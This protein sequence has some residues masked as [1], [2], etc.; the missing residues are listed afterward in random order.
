MTKPKPVPLP[1]ALVVTNRSKTFGNISGEMPTPVS[2]SLMTT[3]GPLSPDPA[4]DDAGILT[5]PPLSASI[6]CVVQQVNEYPLD[7]CAVAV[8]GRQLI[9]EH[10]AYSH[11]SLFEDW[12]KQKQR[13]AD[14]FIDIDF[15]PR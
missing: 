14:Q 5:L 10:R 7:G 6:D 3:S 15:F 13:V 2:V 4:F 9:G 8:D 1:G 12:L 11:A